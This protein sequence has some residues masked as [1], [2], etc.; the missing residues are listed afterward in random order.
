MSGTDD[1]ANMDFL[2]D[3]PL[4]V[5]IELGRTR[6]MVKQLLTLKKNSVIELDREANEPVDI[7]IN[8]K[9]FARGEVVVE[10]DR[11]AI[12]ITDIISPKERIQ[13]LA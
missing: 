11:I 4:E 1:G 7:L 8:N 2:M 3:I 12:M 10:G 9:R 13:R 6:M 5:T